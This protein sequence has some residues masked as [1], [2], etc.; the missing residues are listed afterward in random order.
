MQLDDVMTALAAK[1][2][3]A[4]K[5]IFLKHGAKEPFFGVKVADLKTIAK[6][7][8]GDQSLAL[9]LYATGNGDAQYLAGMVADG[10][11]MS[12]RELQTWADRAGWRMI[13]NTIV[14][15]VA[16]ENPD[17]LAL[18][19]RWID[20]KKE[21]LAQAGWSTLGAWVTTHADAE[22]DMKLL[23]ALLERVTKTIH[24]QPDRV[25]QQ[26][27]YFVIAVGTY[28]APLGDKA[29]AAARQIGRI[30]VDV[31][32]TDCRIPDAESYIMKSR[33]G[34][35]SAPKRATVRC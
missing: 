31:G 21:P 27:N 7:I 17:G 30:A 22:L 16:S 28:V 1:G 6:K 29:I 18:A 23:T 20:A 13:S 32:D 35:P 8:K 2:S 5:R 11:K 4:T 9:E 14:S 12:R 33:R 26:M 34:A 15:W 25:R 19:L 24:A 10:A 3:E